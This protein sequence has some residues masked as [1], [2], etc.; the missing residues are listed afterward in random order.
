MGSPRIS[1]ALPPPGS[2][3]HGIGGFNGS[4]FGGFRGTSSV[5]GGRTLDDPEVEGPSSVPQVT[6]P[7]VPVTGYLS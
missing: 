7:M 1:A 5:Q 2:G 6:G 3:E 4:G